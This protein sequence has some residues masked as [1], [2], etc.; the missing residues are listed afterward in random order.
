M[1]QLASPV[2]IGFTCLSK[3]ERGKLEFAESPS[4]SLIH[5]LADVLDADEDQL[6]LLAKRVPESLTNRIFEHPDVFLKLARCDA[7][8]LSRVRAVW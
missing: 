1:R 8:A 7:A 3:V 6:M 2:G 4:A 5:R